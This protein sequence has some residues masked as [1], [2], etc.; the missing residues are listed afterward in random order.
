M[1]ENITAGGTDIMPLDVYSV[2]SL[3]QIG[4]K[5]TTAG[6]D[7]MPVDVSSLPS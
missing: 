6:T 5:M 4:E 7:I 1:G 3:T 2:T